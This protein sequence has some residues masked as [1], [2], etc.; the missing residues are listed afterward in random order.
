MY[1]R[2]APMNQRLAKGL[3]PRGLIKLLIPAITIVLYA[4]KKSIF[5]WGYH[6]RLLFFCLTTKL[7]MELKIMVDLL[8]FLMLKLG[9]F[10]VFNIFKIICGGGVSYSRKLHKLFSF[11]IVN[12][13]LEMYYFNDQEQWFLQRNSIIKFS[14]ADF[15]IILN[16]KCFC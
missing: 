14:R 11:L 8:M 6:I 12:Y 10:P 15:W 4:L 2:A 16:I 5:N 13:N 9:L 7:L 1:L 3:G